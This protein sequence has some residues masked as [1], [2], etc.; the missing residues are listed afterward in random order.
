VHLTID[1]AEQ[2]PAAEAVIA[3]MYG[4][5]DAVSGLEQQQLVHAVVIADMVHAGTAVQQAVQALND[6]AQ[7]EQGLSAATLQ[8]L[9]GLPAWP[10]CLVKLLPAV[11]NCSGCCLSGATDLAVI[12]AA[13]TGGMMQRLLLALLGDLEAVWADAELQQGLL[14]LP[15]PAMQLLLS[16]DKLKI[17]AEDTVLYTAQE[18]IAAQGT[19]EQRSA[20]AEALTPLV[21]A[22]Q[23]SAFALWCAVVK[24]DAGDMG[25]L[26]GYAHELKRLHSLRR[27]AEGSEL[28][29]ELLEFADIPDSWHLGPRQIKPL[30][31]GVRLEWRLPVEDLKRI[32][33]NSCFTAQ[34]QMTRSPSSSA[35]ICGLG[36][37]MKVI[38]RQQAG[39]TAIGLFAGPKSI[40]NGLFY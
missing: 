37:V 27:I 7:W 1:S 21:R 22:P 39:G 14:A 25:L 12:Q 16:S 34:K 15:L 20:A 6:A 36:W 31:D 38:C 19:A 2:L 17:A 23:L 26:A 11:V 33:R 28:A 35:P 5:P 10:A 24:A 29:A 8:E 18:Y 9:A 30:A 3:A 13:D 32:C 40:L 4:V